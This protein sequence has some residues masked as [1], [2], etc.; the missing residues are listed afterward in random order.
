MEVGASRICC[1]K[2][3]AE[4]EADDGERASREETAASAKEMRTLS[5]LLAEGATVL[6]GGDNSLEHEE[7]LDGRGCLYLMPLDTAVT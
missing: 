5:L 6:Y 7:F 2:R 1:R 4:T 3:A